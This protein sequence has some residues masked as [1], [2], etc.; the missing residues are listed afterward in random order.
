M[1]GEERPSS[2]VWRFQAVS[3]EVLLLIQAFNFKQVLLPVLLGTWGVN[4]RWWIWDPTCSREG[5]CGFSCCLQAAASDPLWAKEE[6]GAQRNGGKGQEA[7]GPGARA[8]F[9]FWVTCGLQ[10]L[11]L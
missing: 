2:A 3:L 10:A 7:R 11:L 8:V 9:W 4:P 1:W 5:V 6:V